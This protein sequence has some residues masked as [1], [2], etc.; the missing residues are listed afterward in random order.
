MT[1][2]D[3][4]DLLKRKYNLQD[5]VKNLS[6]QLETLRRRSVEANTLGDLAP[7]MGQVNIAN[8]SGTMTQTGLTL[9]SSLMGVQFWASLGVPSTDVNGTVNA[10]ALSG[11]DL[12]VGGNFTQ[13]GGIAAANIAKYNIQT[14][15]WSNVGSADALN[16]S[17]SSIVVSG[18]NVFMGGSFTNAGGVANADYIVRWDG[19]AWNAMGAASL[20]GIVTEMTLSGTDLYVCGRFTSVD[21]V[22]GVDYLAKWNGSAWVNITSGLSMSI[23]GIDAVTTS[24][25]DL[26]VGGFFSDGTNK[27]YVQKWDG[28]TWTNLGD[29]AINDVIYC[30]LVNNNDVYVGGN[31]TDAGSA[32]D[33]DYLVRWD[34]STWSAVGS[35]TA[36]NK[37]VYALAMYGNTLIVGGS[38]TNAAD[39][40]SADYLAT[41]NGTNW[42]ALGNAITVKNATTG[43]V[44][45]LLINNTDIYFGGD[46]VTIDGGRPSRS[47]GAY[48]QTLQSVLNYLEASTQAL[49]DDMIQGLFHFGMGANYANFDSNGHLRLYGDATVH[50]DVPPTG[51]SIGSGANAPSFSAY[52]GNMRAYEFVGSA[53]TKEISMVFQMPHSYKEGS[54]VEPHLHLYIPNDATGGVIRFGCEYTWV[55]LDGAEPATTTIYATLTV[56][57][58][59]GAQ[60]NKLFDFATITGTGKTISSLL[61][62]RFFR[63]PTNAADTFGSS[64]WLKSADCH[65]EMDSLGSQTETVK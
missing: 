65:V 20:N 39:L 19:S 36:L 18:S 15:K 45:V 6:T 55:N 22:A 27:Y 25:T 26:Y 29:P 13:I 2:T 42:S 33:A 30:I 5:E 35:G 12:Y 23:I 44:S 4:F 3:P 31:F 34:G 49:Q 48:L 60:G 43:G 24:G 7:N 63:D 64:V 11:T 41:W 14:G 54:S 61:A 56:A 62:C 40:T 46:I 21:G 52:N 28:S 58:G 32:A 38:F 9:N 16:G 50:N 37:R 8:N 59:A 53:L 51:V 17:V 57:A 1:L 10:L 47:I